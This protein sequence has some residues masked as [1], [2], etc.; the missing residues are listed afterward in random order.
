V[1]GVASAGSDGSYAFSERLSSAREYVLRVKTPAD[2]HNQAGAS[3]PFKVAVSAS[4]S[5]PAPTL[6]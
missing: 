5:G 1:I 4:D 3:A 6:E 2:A